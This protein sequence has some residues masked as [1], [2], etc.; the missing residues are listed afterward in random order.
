MSQCIGAAAVQ[1]L[2]SIAMV[3]ALL[4]SLWRGQLPWPPCSPTDAAAAAHGSGRCSQAF[5]DKVLINAVGYVEVSR[6]TSPIAT[7]NGPCRVGGGG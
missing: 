6:V 3:Q 7:A 2:A 4:P 5:M 1:R